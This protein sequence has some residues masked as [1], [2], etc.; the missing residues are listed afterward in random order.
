MSEYQALV[1]GLGNSGYQDE[2]AGLYF[3]SQL[4]RRYPHLP[5]RF[6]CLDNDILNLTPYLSRPVPLLLV[7]SGNLGLIPGQY[8]IFSARHFNPQHSLIGISPASL[9]QLFGS[10]PDL[11]REEFRILA[12][13][14]HWNEMGEEMSPEI[15]Q[16]VKFLLRN[17]W[18]F[19]TQHLL[20]QPSRQRSEF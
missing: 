10:F 16:T 3:V 9:Q 7:T 1:A 4:Q 8:L 19:L 11:Q 17:F 5:L 2:G 14:I 20:L 15:C 12:F 13:Q 6:L 18:Q